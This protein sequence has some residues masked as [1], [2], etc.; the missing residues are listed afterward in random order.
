MRVLLVE[1]DLKL[2]KFTEHMLKN[3]GQFQVEWLTSGEDAYNQAISTSYDVLILDWMLP[4]LNGVSVCQRL[5]KDGY[6]GAIL[7][8][9]A[10]DSVD[11]RVKGL[12]SGA[13]DYLTK[14]FEFSELIARIRVLGRRN[15]APL[16]EDIVQI[17]DI[18]F[19]RISCTMSRGDE[20]IQLTQR[21]F[22]LFD[23]LV[24]NIGI[25]LPR[26]VIFDRIWGIDSDTSSNNVDAYIK[27]LRKKIDLPDQK[28]YITSVRG[29]GYKIEA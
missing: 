20:T 10:K 2:G 19:N 4:D 7:M 18:T 1:D 27:M 24:R 17:K 11:D 14:P 28:S 25:T 8:L 12:E 13:D 23:L 29:V 6:N 26:E 9:T 5:R 15:F 3:Q 21:E 22:Q 16:Q